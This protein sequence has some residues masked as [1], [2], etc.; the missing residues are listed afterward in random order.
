MSIA[1][2]NRWHVF[3][4]VTYFKTQAH[5]AL[6]RLKTYLRSTMGQQR[7]SN[8]AFINIREFKQIA[9]ATS[10]TGA[11]SKKAPK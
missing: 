7:V 11:G 8:F 6:R 5:S 2:D 4:L 10:T 1:K 3:L 9:T